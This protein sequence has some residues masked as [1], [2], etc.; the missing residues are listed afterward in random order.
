MTSLKALI[1]SES[2][3][4]SRPQGRIEAIQRAL[5]SYQVLE[6]IRYKRPEEVADVVIGPST[7]SGF[8]GWV[9]CGSPSRFGQ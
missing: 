5:Y 2:I 7:T 1:E 8:A 4:S 3:D 9:N 6:A